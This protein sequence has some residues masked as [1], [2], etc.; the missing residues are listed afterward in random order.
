M[1]TPYTR[2][3]QDSWNLVSD[4]KIITHNWWLQESWLTKSWQ[5]IVY[6]S[7]SSYSVATHEVL[8]SSGSNWDRFILP[9]PW[10]QIGHLPGHQIS[11]GQGRILC[12]KFATFVSIQETSCFRVRE[13]WFSKDERIERARL[14]NHSQI[15]AW[16]LYLL[17]LRFIITWLQEQLK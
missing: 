1:F 13:R 11:H 17:E 15:L 14:L 8:S 9:Q 5:R 6:S 7:T 10:P 3:K 4:A 2:T 16:I 12:L